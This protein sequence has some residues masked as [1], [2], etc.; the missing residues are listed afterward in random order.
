[1]V[2]T[3][4]YNDCGKTFTRRYT[5]ERHAE[6]HTKEKKNICS[7]CSKTFSRRD[8]KNRHEIHCTGQQE[9]QPGG[10]GLKR[11]R[12]S[13]ASPIINQSSPSNVINKFKV[14]K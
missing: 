5:L 7:K 8:S 9:Q 3:C 1:M 6:E 13:V 14:F 2:F 4:T 10:S 12:I 11:S